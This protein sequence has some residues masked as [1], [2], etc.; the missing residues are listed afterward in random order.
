[1]NKLRSY[2][3]FTPE[4]CEDLKHKISMCRNFLVDRDGFYTLGAATYQDNPM[5]YPAIANAFNVLLERQFTEMYGTLF[6]VLETALG[7]P[8]GRFS[9]NV[10]LP[11]FHVF[12]HKSAGMVGHPHID[13]PF[14]RLDLGDLKWHSPFSFTVAIDIPDGGAGGDFWWDYTDE[15][16]EKYLENGDLPE[17]TFE[18]YE[19]GKLYLHD[20]KT[21]HRIA[22]PEPIKEGQHRI[23]LQGHGLT[24]DNGAVVYF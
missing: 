21:P 2:D 10:G 12:D 15:D 14:T 11:S 16:I 1:M 8:V 17:P 24:T 18:E 9:H 3:M 4:Q 7:M 5:A 20:G 6:E 13:E 22:N 23:T 19:L